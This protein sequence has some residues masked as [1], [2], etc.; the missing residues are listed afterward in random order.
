MYLVTHFLGLNCSGVSSSYSRAAETPD[1][2]QV[3]YLDDPADDIDFVTL[4]NILYFIYTGCVNLPFPQ[5]EPD[6]NPLP[7]GYPSK[8]DPFRLFR[9]AD[10]FLL[11]SLKERCFFHLQHSVTIENVAERL[12]HLDC[13]Q[14]PELKDFYFNY[15]VANYEEVKETEELERVVCNCED[16]SQSA[17]EYR[18]R[19]LLDITKA[20]KP[21]RT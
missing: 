12:F 20:L 1:D 6:I 4:H 3:I 10:K 16:I 7:E 21:S 18:M 13:G 8:P 5:D 19:L 15:L 2:R 9:N 14:Y 17:V 11:Q